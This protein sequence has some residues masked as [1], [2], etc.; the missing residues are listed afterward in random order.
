MLAAVVVA[1]D[2]CRFDSVDTAAAV[3]VV[4]AAAVAGTVDVVVV[5]LTDFASIVEIQN[6]SS[7]VTAFADSADFPVTPNLKHCSSFD[8]YWSTV[9]IRY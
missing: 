8:Y 4:V 3:V 9:I 1:V 7:A 5:G 6:H 2:Y